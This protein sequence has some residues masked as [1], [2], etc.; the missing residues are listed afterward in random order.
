[1]LPLICKGDKYDTRKS[2]KENILRTCNRRNDRASRALLC[3]RFHRAESSFA[4][5]V[6]K[7]KSRYNICRR[8]SG[9]PCRFYLRGGGN[10]PGRET[11]AT[12][13]LRSPTEKVR[14]SPS[15]IMLIRKR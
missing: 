13:S 2:E 11:L 6:H 14:R 9:S 5:Q 8:E 1:M 3:D 10:D 7:T 15:F 4:L 12:A